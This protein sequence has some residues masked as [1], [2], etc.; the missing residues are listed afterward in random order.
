MDLGNLLFGFSGRINRAK[1][2]LALL[3]YFIVGIVIAIIGLLLGQNSIAAQAVPIIV[4]IAITVSAIAVGIK[5]LHDL[6]RTGWWM[7]LFL[8]VPGICIA[9]GMLMLAMGVMG[10]S[11]GTS[12]ASIVL[13]LA[14]LGVIVWYI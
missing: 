2:W 5:R 10:Q 14:G 9:V 1:W 3:V 4:N 8:L 6:D 7:L 12:A 11:G 13:M